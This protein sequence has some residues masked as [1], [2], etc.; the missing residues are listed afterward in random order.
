M[1]IPRRADLEDLTH[2]ELVTLAQEALA[3]LARRAIR[4]EEA[5][6]SKKRE[7]DHAPGRIGW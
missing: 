5:E 1:R 2:S 3:E 6:V 7:R 4:G